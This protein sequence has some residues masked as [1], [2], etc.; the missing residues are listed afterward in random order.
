MFIKKQRKTAE[1]KHLLWKMYAYDTHGEERKKG[2]ETFCFII[3][4]SSQLAISSEAEDGFG[5]KK[6]EG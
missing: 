4:A 5:K 1:E 3:I 2:N 6:Y